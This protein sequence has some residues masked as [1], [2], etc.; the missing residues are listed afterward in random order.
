M[1]KEQQI[2]IQ[3]QEINALTIQEK[4]SSMQCLLLAY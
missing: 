4:V 2:N 3:E 1:N